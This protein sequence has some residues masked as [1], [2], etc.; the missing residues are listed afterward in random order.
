[1]VTSHEID[2]KK[3]TETYGCFN[4][5]CWSV[6]MGDL[7][8]LGAIPP[9]HIHRATLMYLATRV[10]THVIPIGGVQD[11]V[12]QHRQDMGHCLNYAAVKCTVPGN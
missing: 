1:M 2:I 12:T 7:Q 11:L 8:I 4:N 10:L 6:C 5:F 3:T 9:Q